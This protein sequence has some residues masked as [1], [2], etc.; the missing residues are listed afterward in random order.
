MS[1]HPHPVY[2]PIEADATLWRYMSLEKFQ[3][4]LADRALFFCRADKFSD[5]YE[6]SIPRREAEHRI[7]EAR[8]AA[9]FYQQHFDEAGALATIRDRAAF[10]QA[11]KYATIVNCW[12]INPNES[13]GM[14]RLYMDNNEGVAIQT[15]GARITRTMEDPA[16]DIEMSK[17]R[18]IDYERDIW[19]HPEDFPHRSYNM[20]TPLI[21]KRAEFGHEQEFRLFHLIE[22]A[23][24]TTDY[25]QP[26]QHGRNIPVN[27][28]TLIERVC[29]HP[30]AT[31]ADC[32]NV[33]NLLAAAGLDKPV[34]FSQLNSQPYY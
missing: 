20:I 17:V 18:Y 22:V 13:D 6:G 33:L 29:L 28:D 10:H 25:W 19:Y 31:E 11:F 4:L 15:T 2:T 1:V 9:D 12:H 26:D 23:T 32:N 21:H 8:R 5:I 16:E 30:T 24:R 27:L 34:V 14:W 7:S 3:R